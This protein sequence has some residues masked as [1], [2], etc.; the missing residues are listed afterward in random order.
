VSV[1]EAAPEPIECPEE[2]FSENGVIST[3]R[4]QVGLLD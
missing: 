2:A 1:S 3:N 4:D